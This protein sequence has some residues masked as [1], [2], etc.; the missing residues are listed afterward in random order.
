MRRKRRWIILTTIDRLSRTTVKSAVQV[1]LIGGGIVGASA[2]YWLAKLDWTDTLLR[3]I[4]HKDLHSVFNL[5]D[6]SY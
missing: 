6:L 2:L 3:L 5:G 4:S 1:A